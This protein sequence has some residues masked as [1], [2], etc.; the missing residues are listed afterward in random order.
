MRAASGILTFSS[1]VVDQYEIVPTTTLLDVSDYYV[2][3]TITICG[4]VGHDLNF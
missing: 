2:I 4:F 1:W 3:L